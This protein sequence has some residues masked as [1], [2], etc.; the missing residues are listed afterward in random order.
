MRP[1]T[2]AAGDRG[3][4]RFSI[5][6]FSSQDWR[7]DL[8]TNRQQI[9]RRAAERG[10]RVLFVETGGFIGTHLARLLRRN[11]MSVARRLFGVEQVADDVGVT[12]ALNVLP[13]GQKYHL[14]NRLNNR[15]TRWRIRRLAGRLPAPWV[16]WLYDPASARAAI[17]LGALV[18]YDCVDDYSEQVPDEKRKA[19]V[20][21]EDRRAATSG[22]V[23][24]AT[25]HSLVD[26]HSAVNPHTHLVANVGDFEH[27][28]PAA[29]RATTA[30]DVAM[31][32]RPVLGFAGNFLAAKVDFDLLR[33][34]AEALPDATVL[35]IGPAHDDTRALLDDLTG[36]PNVHWTG[37]RAYSD[38]PAYVASFDVGLIPYVANAY[39]RSCFP[40]KL[41]EYLAAGKPVVAS[42]LPELAEMEPDVALAATGPE[43]VQAVVAA[44]ELSS[45]DDCLRRMSLAAGNTW[46]TRT[47][48]LLELVGQRLAGMTAE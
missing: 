45:H 8:P 7:V 2:T 13:W 29:D 39:T 14:A 12:K 19:L 3:A 35:L 43:F 4:P 37:P 5:V 28:S 9:M 10:H 47:E 34:L 16:S 38:L 44:L 22:D 31:L 42:G 24:F 17:G 26:R 36:L 40:L 48:K 30:P 11:G 18:A 1:E 25:T 27:F 20:A 21:Q 33:T 6:C 15:V 32:P 41:Y 23:V 46:D